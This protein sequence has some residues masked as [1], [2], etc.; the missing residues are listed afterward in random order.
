MSS[1]IRK[2]LID[3]GIS[4]FAND[5]VAYCIEDGELQELEG[6]F[7]SRVKDL[8]RHLVIDVDNDHNTKETAERLARMYLY[9]IFKVRYHFQPKV[10]SFLNVKQLDEID[11]VGPITVR[12]AC[13]HHFVPILGSC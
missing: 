7:T 9:E 3:N 12:S 2:R 5:N 11:T 8:L 13:S 6:E 1:R 4:F 10:T